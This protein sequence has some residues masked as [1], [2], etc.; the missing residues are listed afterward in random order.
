METSVRKT[1][2]HEVRFLV[3]ELPKSNPELSCYFNLKTV[4]ISF[5][6]YSKRAIVKSTE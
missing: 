4:S 6:N 1:I 3:N 5:N 2:I